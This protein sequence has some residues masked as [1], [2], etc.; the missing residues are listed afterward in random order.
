MIVKE[1]PL[2]S[3]GKVDKTALRDRHLR[4]EVD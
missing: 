2:T 4:D 1:L 3:V